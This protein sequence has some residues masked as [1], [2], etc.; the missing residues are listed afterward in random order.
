[1]NASKFLQIALLAFVI[2]L[3]MQ[4]FLP[5]PQNTTVGQNDIS[6]TAEANSVTIPTIPAIT[7]HNSTASDF[8]Y[9]TCQDLEISVNSNPVNLSTFPEFCQDV[10]VKSG[11]GEKINMNT[12]HNVYA[13]HAG[14]H[15]F[16]LQKDEIKKNLVVTVENRGFIRSFFATTVYDPIYNLFAGL[17]H[18]LPGHPLGWAIII[19][20]IIIRLIL[21]IPQHKALESSR[22][23]AEINPKIR[24]LQEEYKEDRA[25]LGMKMMELYKKEGVNPAGSCLPLLIQMPILLALY[26]VIMGIND[27]SNTFHLYP[28]L[29]DFNPTTIEETFLGVN[30]LQIGGIAAVIAAVILAATQWLQSYLTVKAQP[31]PAKKTEKKP[32]KTD[33][34][35]PEMPTLDPAMM[36]KMMLYFFPLLIGVTALFF[37]L[38]LSLYWFI[39]IVF[40]IA[41]QWYVNY[42]ADQKKSKGEIIRK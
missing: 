26:W 2:T 36:Q 42:R 28:F 31:Q 14:Q 40:M 20:T 37:P 3:V 35:T 38:G 21:L 15:I 24:A 16:T 23:M 27:I 10:I 32:A 18:Y 1:M 8:A 30:L 11:S 5:K 39:G 12:L 6:I 41:Q 13:N 34:E 33:S 17:I 4:M 7:V 22:R 9:N 19:I 29:K 25:A